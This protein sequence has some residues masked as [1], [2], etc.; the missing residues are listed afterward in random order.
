LFILTIKYI[1]IVFVQDNEY[2]QAQE[3]MQTQTQVADAI[4]A[5]SSRSSWAAR[6]NAT[7]PVNSSNSAA[8]LFAS[9]KRPSQLV[10]RAASPSSTITGSSVQSTSRSHFAPSTFTTNVQK[11]GRQ[12]RMWEPASGPQAAAE[13]DVALADLAHSNL[14]G[15][16]FGEDIK[17]QLVLDIARRLPPS[18]T[19]PGRFKMGGPLLTK[20]YDINWSKETHTLLKE[21]LIYG[22]SLFGDGATIK[23]VPMLNAL[24]AGVHNSFAMLD[25][26]D[27]T[28]HC[29]TGGKKDAP[30]IANL[31]L[32]LISK[33]ESMEDPYA[34]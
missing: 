26:F 3:I 24:G 7:N 5:L 2:L 10:D 34:S 25:V 19:P 13:M 14:Y 1:V 16:S 15:S 20:L 6:T 28:S 23:T 4:A 9:R 8:S 31:F 32:P 30:Y 12:L 29:A 22:I 21:A 33:L 27:C 11:K 18:Y 17:L